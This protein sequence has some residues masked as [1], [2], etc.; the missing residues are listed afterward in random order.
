MIGG[1]AFALFS[2][3]WFGLGDKTAWY[4]LN[5]VAHT[6]WRDAPI[7]GEFHLG[8]AVLG[9]VTLA[10]VGALALAPFAAI[11]LLVGMNVLVAIAAAVIYANI[12]WVIGHYLLW[13]ALDPVA[14]TRFTPGV[15]WSAHFVA[16]L[17]AGLMLAWLTSRKY[18]L[19]G[20]PG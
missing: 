16:G 2:M 17:A 15:A 19:R 8:S 12:I 20:N 14:A 10:V 3:I 5:L 13:E 6:V 1:L 9:L 11:A 4:P 18:Q 7:D